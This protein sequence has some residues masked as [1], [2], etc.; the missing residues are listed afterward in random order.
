MKNKIPDNSIFR[1]K[2]FFAALYAC[3]GVVLVLAAVIS[4]NNIRSMTNPPGKVDLSGNSGA[5]SAADDSSQANAGLTLPYQAP[6]GSIPQ[7]DTSQPYS[8]Q[9]NTVLASPGLDDSSQA[10]AGPQI[11]QSANTDTAGNDPGDITGRTNS[12]TLPKPSPSKAPA[13]QAPASADQSDTGSQAAVTDDSGQSAASDTSGSSDS[14]ATDDTAASSVTSEQDQTA[15]VSDGTDSGEAFPAFSDD[16]KM[17]WPVLGDIV[18]DFSVD[19]VIYDKT[20]DQYRTND[21]ICIAAQ[22]G[23]QVKAAAAGVVTQ[24]TKDNQNGNTVVIDDGNGWIT[25]YGQLM[26]GVL[27]K[28]GDVVK[29]GQVIGGVAAPTIYGVLLGDHVTF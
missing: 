20:L 15:S 21:N 14:S 24:V 12:P 23:A 7:D 6:G 4:Y 5:S 25:T 29:A 18:M 9:D 26:D 27:V 16:Q 10:N 1:K 13:K 28:E 17:S 8:G 3:V 22:P 11:G 2:G 19:H